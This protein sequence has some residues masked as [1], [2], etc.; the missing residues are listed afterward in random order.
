MPVRLRSL[1]LCLFLPLFV[2]AQPHK[3]IGRLLPHHASLQFAGGIGF[4]AAGVGYGTKNHRLLGD[5]YYGYVPEQ[6]GGVAIHSITGKITWAPLSHKLSKT[7][8]WQMLTTGLLVNYAFGKQYFLFSPP[9]YPYSYYGFPT[10]L[11]VGIFAGGGFQYKRLQ[12]YYE[13][14]TTDKELLSYIGNTNSL[15]FGDILNIAV[16]TRISFRE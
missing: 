10:S 6:V 3:G 13:L 15:K 11:H 14:G 2:I 12:L 1:L 16:G 5:F 7:M 4:F 9:N 8:R